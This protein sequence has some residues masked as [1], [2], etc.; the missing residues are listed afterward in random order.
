MPEKKTELDHAVR[1]IVDR[2]FEDMF[3]AFDRLRG[4]EPADI[5]DILKK[6]GEVDVADQ[7]EDWLGE[8]APT[9]PKPEPTPTALEE[10]TR[11]MAALREKEN[12]DGK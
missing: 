12:T 6:S 10:H 9:A 4:A 3:E 7:Y 5:L 1:R 8:D 11:A 2:G